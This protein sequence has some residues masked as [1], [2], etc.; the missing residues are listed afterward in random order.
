MKVLSL[1]LILVFISQ[2]SYGISYHILNPAPEDVVSSF[3][4]ASVSAY[5]KRSY[6]RKVAN[7]PE[8]EAAVKISSGFLD[9]VVDE[10]INSDMPEA[11][12]K[13][14]FLIIGKEAFDINGMARRSLGPNIGRI[15]PKSKKEEFLKNYVPLYTEYAS[16]CLL[17]NNWE[18]LLRWK[19]MFSIS[20]LLLI[21][22]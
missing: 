18:A 6:W 21:V 17:T 16:W 5:K 9:D 2:M 1:S 7:N 4:G 19:I 3:M 8:E 15:K 20:L 11:E 12:K 13:E 10:I 22:L 14:K